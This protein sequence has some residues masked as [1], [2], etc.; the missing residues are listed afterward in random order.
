MTT[1]PTLGNDKI[2]AFKNDNIYSIKN[3]NML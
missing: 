2:Q 3:Y 1:S